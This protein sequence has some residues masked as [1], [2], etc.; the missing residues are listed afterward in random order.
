MYFSI[1]H[2]DRGAWQLCEKGKEGVGVRK[3][4]AGFI[5][6]SSNEIAT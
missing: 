3:G 1:G 6:R 2:R 4:G 5:S